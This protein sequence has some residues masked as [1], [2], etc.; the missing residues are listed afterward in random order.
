MKRIVLMT[1]LFMACLFAFSGCGQE[2]RPD[3]MPPLHLCR[4]TIIQDGQP[5][6]GAIVTLHNTGQGTNWGSSGTTAAS[7]VA[8]IFT[9]GQYKGAPE[10]NYKVTVRKEET[11]SLATPE[12]L[13]AIEKAK[14]ENPKWFDPPR[15]KQETWQLVEKQY[16][17]DKETPLELVI[18]SGKNNIEFD[19]GKAVRERMEDNTE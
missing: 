9:Q 11:V 15:I 2:R 17:D 4:I 6:E 5:L 13:A 10:G 1:P 16:T 14:A 8:D 19:L 7:G 3:G 12:Q 18:S